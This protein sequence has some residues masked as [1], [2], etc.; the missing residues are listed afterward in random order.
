M[1]LGVAGPRV[2]TQAPRS[3]LL[4]VVDGL[5]PD[6]IT[7]EVMPRLY[8]LGQRG[9][10]FAAHHSVFPTVT[11]VNASSISTGAYPETHGL[12]GNTVYSAKVF[13]PKGINTSAYKELEAMEK[14]EGQLLTAPTLSES[15]GR[16]G[17]KMLV[18]SAGS[19]GSALLL[20]HRLSGGAVINP[21]VIK[22]ES[23]AEL[24]S[25]RIGPGPAE[26]V[27]NNA[28]NKWA[29]DAYLTL[30]LKDLKSDVTAIWFGDPDA[31]AHAKGIGSEETKQALGYVD[32]QI[33]RIEDALRADGLLE[34]TNILVTSDHGFSTHTGELR[35]AALVAPF[36]KAMPD[37]TP[38]L[39]VTEGAVNFRAGETRPVWL[40]S[41]PSFRSTRKSARSSPGRRPM[42][43]RR[44]LCPAPCRST[45]RGGTI[46]ARPKSS[47]PATGPATRTPPVSRV[48]RRREAWPD[49]ER[50]A[51]TTFTT[52]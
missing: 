34:R 51:R 35:L 31:T 42:A 1:V 10:F 19:S 49:M 22:P 25:T 9:V 44:A 50:R 40:R 46:R 17:M 27:P 32:A 29:V 38:D 11:R 5:R 41:S 45:L 15:L 30:G 33:G 47:S 2:E 3:Q 36:A 6:Y 18:I 13:P 26:A 23:L 14:A 20:N 12:M 48:R 37:G 21:E 43:H 16:A 24:V 28:R 8:A 52:R 4:L 39:V 7:P